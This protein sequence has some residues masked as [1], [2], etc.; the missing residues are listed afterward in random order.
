MDMM[1]AMAMIALFMIMLMTII[2]LMMTIMIW[3]MMIKL[4]GYALSIRY[5][6]PEGATHRLLW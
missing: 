1:D 4:M 2:K 5:E 6:A 3:L